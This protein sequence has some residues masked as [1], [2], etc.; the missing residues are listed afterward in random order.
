MLL[1][2][3]LMPDEVTVLIWHQQKI[4]SK[5]RICVKKKYSLICKRAKPTL[6]CREEIIAKK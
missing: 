5:T 2:T 4:L 6:G 3:L 1:F